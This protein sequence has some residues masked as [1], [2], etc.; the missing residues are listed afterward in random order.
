MVSKKIK[1][2]IPSHLSNVALVGITVNSLCSKLLNKDGFGSQME[3]CV[4]EVCNNIIEHA[5]LSDDKF[6]VDVE[7]I[8]F[9][10]KLAI[11]ISDSGKSNEAGINKTLDFDPDDLENLPEGGMGLFIINETMDEV[12][13]H[14]ENGKNTFTMLKYY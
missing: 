3:L 2:I 1:L 11:N 14:T 10:D 7:L 6:E 9:D 4:V 13:Y 5:Y 8:F 12:S